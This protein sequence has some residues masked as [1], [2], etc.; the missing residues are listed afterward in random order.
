MKWSFIIIL[1][2][3]VSGCSKDFLHEQPKG[4][5]YGDVAIS[6]VPSLDAA[7]TGAYKGVLRT[8]SRGF[9]TASFQGFSMGGDDLTTLAGGNKASKRQIDQFDV[10]ADNP[11]IAQI[12]NGCYKM[13]QGAN[14]VIAN[15]PKILPTVGGDQSQTALVND[16]MGEAYFLRAMG[17]YWL[18]RGW[19]PIPLLTQISY[20]VT[21]ELLNI[22]RSQPKDVY[23]VIEDD[24]KKA[25]EL[26]PDAKRDP[27]RP[28]KGSAMALLADVYLTEGG[29]PVKDAS[30]YALA[31]AEAK[32]VIDNKDRFG[33]SLV[34]LNLLWSETT[35]A[36][37][38]SAKEDV[39]AFQTAENYG[40][41]NNSFTGASTIPAEEGGWEDYESEIN[42]FNN[43]PEGKRKN[44]TFHTI[45]KASDGSMVPWQKSISGHPYYAKFRIDNNGNWWSAQPVH[46]IRYAKV[47]LCYAEAQARAD[48]AP[49]S[50][51]YQAL[52]DVRLRAG[53]TPVSG[54]SPSDFINL[55]VNER[56]WEFAGEGTTRWFDLQRLEMVEEMN[57]DVHR[58]VL[59]NPI[60]GDHGKI[61]EALYWFPVPLT[62]QNINPNLK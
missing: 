19:G 24:L 43:F 25:S 5:V 4:L 18:V 10:T 15:G 59:E 8:W 54:L 12:W 62:D 55:A 29:W 61:T 23:Q 51:A 7:L 3:I 37:P 22:E 14:N 27:G 16:I 2:I 39:F 1:L 38:G 11:D 53:E 48:G 21:P 41:S 56:G 36:P 44:L 40:G 42:F 13:I 28:N 60:I 20:E 34:D 46:M 33:F 57:D 30:K 31:A 47:L 49:N 26:L 32:Q 50:D 52:N 17:Y 58:N 35:V 9:L 45:F 6:D